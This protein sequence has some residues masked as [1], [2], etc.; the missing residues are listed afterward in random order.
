MTKL[1]IATNNAHKVEEYQ[2][3]LADLPFTLTTPKAEGLDLDPDET[4]TTFV[5]NAIIKAEA[6]AQASGLLTL[7]DDSGLEI[8]ALNGEPGVFSA[9]Y[10]QTAKHDHEARYQLVLTKMAHCE[11]PHRTARFRCVI[12]ITTP[13][14]LVGTVDGAV[15]GFITFAPQGKGGFGYDPVFY[16]PEFECTMAELT[17]AQKHSISHRGLAARQAVNLLAEL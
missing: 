8:D 10:G 6:F 1:L 13:N 17:S 7:A 15:E 11:W 9:R 4:G 2:E 16:V 14:Q 5:E 12:A 3:I